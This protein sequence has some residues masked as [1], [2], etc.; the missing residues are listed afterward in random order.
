MPIDS[1]LLDRLTL[2]WQ[3]L[4]TE[5]VGPE[6]LG[7][8]LPVLGGLAQRYSEPHRHYHTL[9]H[10]LAMLDT[11]AALPLPAASQPAV[12]LAVWFHDAIYDPKASDNEE[13]SAAFART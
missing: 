4:W 6:N 10:L 1:V 3:R 2:F 7:P 11:L 8:S 9:D 12:Q 5:L 13:R